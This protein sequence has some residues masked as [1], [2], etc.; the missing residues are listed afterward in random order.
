MRASHDQPTLQKSADAYEVLIVGAGPVG[1]ALSIELGHRGIRCLVVEQRD[2]VGYNPRAKTTNVRTREH[3]RRWGLDEALRAASPIPPDYPSDIIF[4]TRLDGHVLARF[5]NAFHTRRE[6]NPLFSSEAQWVPQYVLEEVL[7][8]HASSLPAITIRFNCKCESAREVAGGVSATLVDLKLGERSAV[9]FQYVVGADG[10]RSMVRELIGAR[11]EGEELPLRNL[12]IVLRSQDLRTRIPF[13]DAIHYWLVNSEM[14]CVFGPMDIKNDLWYLIVTKVSD[15]I[16]TDKIDS[17]T[18]VQQAL[19]SG[20]T[21][22]VVGLDPWIARS[23]IASHY[24]KGRFFSRAMRAICT[25]RSAAT[26]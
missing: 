18:L 2:R 26:A 9:P 16:A 24:R 3:L 5:E 20:F 11:M 4:A 15:D 6:R 7:R 21:F 10:A 17:R 14:P 8:A 25:H 19:G 22:D 13:G 12:N 1:L 23:L